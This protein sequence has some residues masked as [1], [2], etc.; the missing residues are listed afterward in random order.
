MNTMWNEKCTR[1]NKEQNKDI[2]NRVIESTQAKQ[3]KEKR[4]KNNE[5]K[6]KD[7]YHK[8]QNPNTDSIEVLEEKTEKARGVLE[9]KTEEKTENNIKKK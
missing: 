5:D 9:E 6:L 8:F 4:I 1:G 7:L 2:E 3:Q